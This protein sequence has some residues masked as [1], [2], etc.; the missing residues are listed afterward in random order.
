MIW[1]T[2]SDTGTGIS[3]EDQARIFERFYK[4]D[5]V[6]TRAVE[7]VGK[8]VKMGTGLGLAI[9]KHIVEAHGGKI[10]MES[11]LGRGATCYFS[12]PP[13]E[14]PPAQYPEI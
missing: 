13:E 5:E 14:I 10:W 8:T 3:Q 11:M 7:E 4:Q 2:V 12:L 9:A 1:V 6:R